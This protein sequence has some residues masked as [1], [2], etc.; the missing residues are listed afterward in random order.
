MEALTRT[1]TKLENKIGEE[2]QSQVETLTQDIS[3]TESKVNS[4]VEKKFKE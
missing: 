3:V 2:V 4:I 1:V